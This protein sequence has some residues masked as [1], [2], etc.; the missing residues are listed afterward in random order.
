MSEHNSPVVIITG[1]SR[2][3]GAATARWLATQSARIT[4][5]ARSDSALR[6][7]AAAV[8]EQGGTP[9]T[10]PAD[11]SERKAC[12]R[13]IETTLDRFGRLDALVNNAGV[14]QPIAPVADADPDKW[15]YTINVNLIAPFYLMHAALPALR[16]SRGRIINVSTGLAVSP[17]QG[18]SAYCASKAGFLHLTRVVA[19]EEPAVTSVSLRPGA[20]DTEMQADLRQVD[21]DAMP[22][23]SRRRFKRL[24]QEGQL[25]SPE[26]PA[27]TIAWL[28]LHAPGE[29]S[30]EFIEYDEPRVA[31]PANALFR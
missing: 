10:I 25:E 1:A 29:W 26:V 12:D 8:E 22:D 18:V 4:L 15:A 5:T 16:R 7:V 21:A 20:I 28:A 3:L 27:R 2:G 6:K 31:Q 9:L 14:L 13:L 23:A 24:K 17:M 30:G 19:A 11:I